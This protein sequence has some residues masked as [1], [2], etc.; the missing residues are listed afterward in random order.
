MLLSFWSLKVNKKGGDKLINV[1]ET[2]LKQTIQEKGYKLKYVAKQIG[3]SSYGLGLKLSGKQEFKV[4]EINKLIEI[5]SLT[6]DEIQ[7]IFFEDSVHL[8]TTH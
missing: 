1:N 3:L 7:A 6:D 8:K 2:L 5:L 4:T